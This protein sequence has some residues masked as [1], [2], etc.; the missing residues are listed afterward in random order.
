MS[1][2]TRPFP[3]RQRGAAMLEFAVVGPVVTLLGLASLQYS[4]LFFAKNQMNHATFMAARAGSTGHADLGAIQDAY[5][6]AL[7]PVY[8]G[9]TNAIELAAAYENAAADVAANARIELLNPTKESF[10]DWNDSELQATL[11]RG[12]RVIPNGGLA[13]KDP[14]AIGSHSGQNIQDANLIKIRITHGYLPRVP[15]MG[16]IYTRYLAWLDTGSD[17]FNTQLIQS[18]R[19]P[20]VTHA[21]VQMQSDA[22]EPANPAS[23]P[24]PGNNGHPTDPGEPPTVSTEAP[25]C[26]TIG[27]TSTTPSDPPCDPA[28]DPTC[29]PVL[30]KAGDPTC[31]PACKG[32]CCKPAA[33]TLPP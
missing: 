12:R 11:G 17:A 5:V 27:C 19:I 21:T 24:G 25:D 31:D 32:V 15:L 4:L 18:G 28:T 1:R 16:L 6:R 26:L 23:L 33:I 9:G 3:W 8:G 20:V 14:E 13:F 2:M 29:R 22:I 10:D 30:C 7:I